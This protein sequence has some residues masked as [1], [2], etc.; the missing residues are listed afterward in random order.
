MTGKNCGKSYPFLMP[1]RPSL[2]NEPLVKRCV[3]I[4]Q[5]IRIMDKR[6]K[7]TTKHK[8][9]DAIPFEQSSKIHFLHFIMSF[10]CAL[11]RYNFTNQLA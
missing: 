3:S 11:F 8:S 6:Q 5:A 2:L 7:D 9:Y 4:M 1:L 10:P